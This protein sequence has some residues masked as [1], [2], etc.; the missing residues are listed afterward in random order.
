MLPFA[1]FSWHYVQQPTVEI[2]NNLD[3]VRLSVVEFGF[4]ASCSYSTTTNPHFNFLLC[5]TVCLWVLE[6]ENCCGCLSLI[7]AHLPVVSPSWG[8]VTASSPQH[9]LC[10]TLFV[11]AS[12]SL[13][14][15]PEPLGEKKGKKGEK[16]LL[17]KSGGCSPLQPVSQTVSH[18]FGLPCCLARAHLELH[19]TLPPCGNDRTH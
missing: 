3:S 19:S 5:Q 13:L 11:S 8:L 16:G 6:C 7:A 12:L 10:F 4:N 17:L 18:L 2:S 1:L 14:S 9:S 15:P